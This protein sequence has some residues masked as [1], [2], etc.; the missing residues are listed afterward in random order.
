MQCK[1]KTIYGAHSEVACRTLP[2]LTQETFD[3]EADS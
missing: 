1:T 2:L 3:L